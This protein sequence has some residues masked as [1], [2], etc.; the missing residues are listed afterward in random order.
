M[1]AAS[2]SAGETV[3]GA[4]I[5]RL[6]S[7][8]DSDFSPTLD[9]T[10][11]GWNA[12]KPVKAGVISAA[13]ASGGGGG[14]GSGGSDFPRG[15]TVGGQ[16]FYGG[17]MLKDLSVDNYIGFASS[18]DA[19]ASDSFPAISISGGSGASSGGTMTVAGGRHQTINGSQYG[20]PHVY[21]GGLET[22][23]YGFV[24]RANEQQERVFRGGQSAVMNAPTITGV[25]H[26]SSVTS[27]GAVIDRG[28]LILSGPLGPKIT[29]DS[30]SIVLDGAFVSHV[31]SAAMIT[32]W[33]MT[34]SRNGI[35]I[36][37]ASLGFGVSANN[38]KPFIKSADLTAAAPGAN[39]TIIGAV[40]RKVS[41]GVVATAV[42][43][44]DSSYSVL[45]AGVPNGA[46]VYQIAA[47]AVVYETLSGG[48]VNAVP[49]QPVLSP[50]TMEE[51]SA[52]AATSAGSSEGDGYES[53]YSEISAASQASAN[54][55]AHWLGDAFPV[56][57]GAIAALVSR[58]EAL[59]ARVSALSS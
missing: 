54:E 55:S 5:R 57:G 18:G 32:P 26:I 34:C 42:I 6:S 9:S 38:I 8:L 50:E 59:E 51:I 47:G 2:A 12:D 23:A 1:A 30:Q 24:I 27:K 37:A 36:Y 4:V 45:S 7:K 29:I 52:E 16:Y 14:G 53:A 3:M 46:Q 19:S 11:A 25:M 56:Q 10:S 20:H 33:S 41:S 13:I 49:V 39:E 48:L 35:N 40:L 44:L 43:N 22:S 21:F 58:I 17:V 15:I 28:A 31:S